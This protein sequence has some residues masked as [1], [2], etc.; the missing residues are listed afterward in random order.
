MLNKQLYSPQPPKAPT[1]AMPLL[2]QVQNR[3][4][5]IGR[6]EKGTI[7]L[8]S[9]ADMAEWEDSNT[10]AAAGLRNRWDG[11]GV[12]SDINVA[13]P[14]VVAAPLAAE[15]TAQSPL[16]RWT[17]WDTWFATGIQEATPNNNPLEAHNNAVKACGWK[18]NN[19]LEAHNNAV[20]A[21]GWK[22]NPADAV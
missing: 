14:R 6:K 4:Q 11:A 5:Y 18:P 19:P 22:P 15:T 7:S 1:R 12:M 10:N 21:C 2:A 8:H 16:P 17:P 9:R 20:K 3:K 13:P